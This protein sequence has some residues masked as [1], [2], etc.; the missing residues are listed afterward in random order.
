M[1]AK[2]QQTLACHMDLTQNFISV[3]QRSHDFFNHHQTSA[4]RSNDQR[5]SWPLMLNRETALQ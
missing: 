3:K 2:H 1:S 5:L 4:L